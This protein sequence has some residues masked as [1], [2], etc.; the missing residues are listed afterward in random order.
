MK[1]DTH[2]ALRSA[3]VVVINLTM[4]FGIV[5]LAVVQGCLVYYV[6]S[7]SQGASH[8]TSAMIG[9]LGGLTGFAA[10]YAGRDHALARL[11][12]YLDPGPE[13]DNG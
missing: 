12:A 10:G 6:L 1:R 3:A 9:L 5:V 7:V 4:L 8:R 11:R 2:I 13:D